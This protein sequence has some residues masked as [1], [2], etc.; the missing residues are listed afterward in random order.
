MDSATK[1]QEIMKRDIVSERVADPG[2]K[3]DN[4]DKVQ[5]DE[6]GMTQE[7]F[8]RYVSRFNDLPVNILWTARA[9]RR[10]D[11]NGDTF[12][13]PDI[14]GKDYEVAMWFAAEQHAF[15]YAHIGTVKDAKGNPRQA[16][17]IR[18]KPTKGVKAKDRFDCL[19]AVTR[20]KSLA[21]L[22]ELIIASNEV[23][24]DEPAPAAK[25]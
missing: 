23:D 20:E 25:K 6:Y 15:G 1:M 13:C 12:V 8:K 9:M 2:A 24:D 14:H 19:P 22:R 4:P 17:Q 3:S 5:L 7:R 18:W 16:Y 10:E 21:Y 11:E